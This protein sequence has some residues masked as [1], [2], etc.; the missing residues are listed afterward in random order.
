MRFINFDHVLRVT[1]PCSGN[2]QA[3][4]RRMLEIDCTPRIMSKILLQFLEQQSRHLKD[5]LADR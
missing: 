4:E 1:G 2:A 5:N 3:C